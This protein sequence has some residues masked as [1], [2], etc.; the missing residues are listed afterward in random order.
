MPTFMTEF[1]DPDDPGTCAG[2]YIVASTFAEA[3]KIAGCLLM[4]PDGV[5]VVVVGEL[6][7]QLPEDA[8]LGEV[9]VA[10]RTVA[11]EVNQIFQRRTA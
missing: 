10:Q 5:P 9:R 7:E 2:P 6:I 11:E 4:E 8:E 3:E 1:N